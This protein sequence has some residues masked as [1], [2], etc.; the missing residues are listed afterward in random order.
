MT[1]SAWI[2]IA[3][4]LAARATP[5]PGALPIGLAAGGTSIAIDR[6]EVSLAQFEAFAAKGYLDPS[7]WSPA[8]RRWL[9][10]HPGGAGPTARA[11]GRGPDHPVVAVT[12]Y[13]AEAYCAWRGGRLPTGA[14]WELAACGARPG[15]YPWGEGEPAGPA[16]YHE[17]KYGLVERVAT[18][19]ADAQDAALDSPAGLR[20]AAGNVWE[21]TAEP[22]RAGGG[23]DDP[24]SPW[25]TLRGGSY[26][27]LP[28]YCT[29][30][31]RE[32]ALPDE[33]RLTVGFRCAYDP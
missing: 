25:V 13:E 20:H 2:P 9:A 14:E 7:L 22:Y 30:R 21:W 8:G 3:A 5:P 31:H 24:R 6:A 4:A 17:G 26:A 29:C 27:N 23:P 18:L 16:W 19:P 10:A 33:P 32:P 28:S 15:T 1:R 11:A 12:L